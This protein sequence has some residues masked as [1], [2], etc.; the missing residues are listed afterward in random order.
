M[1]GED[2]VRLMLRRAQLVSLDDSGSQQLLDLS[3]L[4]ADRPRKVPRVMEFGFA[5]S[6]PAGA[7]F[8]MLAAGGGMSRA[9]AI[10]GEHKDHR[11]ANLPSGAAV[12]YDASGNVIFAKSSAGIEVKAA[13]GKITVSPALGQ[14]LFLGGDGVVGTYQPVRTATGVSINVMARIA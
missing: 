3:A 1:H 10:G 5:S 8:L 7:D 11:Q 2:E 4:K 12:L 14:M 13:E 9:M 6:P